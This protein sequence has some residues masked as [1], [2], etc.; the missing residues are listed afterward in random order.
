MSAL[1]DRAG[2][3][4]AFIAELTAEL[5][6]GESARLRALVA[7]F[8]A[9][10]RGV[11]PVLLSA[12]RAR[13][14][15]RA[16]RASRPAAAPPRARAA[17]PGTAHRRGVVATTRAA[18][19]GVA[20][21]ARPRVSARELSRAE[22]ARVARTAALAE[23]ERLAQVAEGMRFERARLAGMRA[24]RERL[25]AESLRPGSTAAAAARRW[26]AD[27]HGPAR[28]RRARWLAGVRFACGR[29]APQ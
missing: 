7:G 8:L 21:P 2:R 3:V 15:A 25:R 10:G 24:A 4:L 18:A 16:T 26:L 13:D 27:H 14:R 6:A 19:P 11:D 12:L 5:P 17:A 23:R 22:Y 29:G 9:S 20:A 28:D 1:A